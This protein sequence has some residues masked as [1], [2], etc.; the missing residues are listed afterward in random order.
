MAY[1]RKAA[2][3]DVSR[4]A[5]ILIFSKRTHYR[6]IF[7]NDAVSFGAMQ[8]LPLARHYLAHPETLEPV[9][10]YDDGLVKGML[11]AGEGELKE[12]YVEPFFE[13]QGVGTALLRFGVEAL[14]VRRLWVLE[15]NHRAIA[16]YRRHGFAL[17]GARLPEEG[18][19]EFIVR[20]ER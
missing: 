15:R 18:T 6:A 17:T 19:A 1:I 7:R 5:E 13:G 10:V 2:A 11:Q 3:E 14:G 9:W 12:L 16:F 20:M 4:L 8:V